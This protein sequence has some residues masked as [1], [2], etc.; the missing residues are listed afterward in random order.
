MKMCKYFGKKQSL[1]HIFVS[2][3]NHHKYCM[4]VN[5]ALGLLSLSFMGRNLFGLKPPKQ[6][7]PECKAGLVVDSTHRLLLPSR[8]F[9]VGGNNISAQGKEVRVQLSREI[10]VGLSTGLHT[11]FC[12]VQQLFSLCCAVPS[13]QSSQ[14]HPVKVKLAANQEAHKASFLPSRLCSRTLRALSQ[15]QRPVIMQFKK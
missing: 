8:D 4:M 7:S 9:G 13:L 1:K 2:D 10:N 12:P 3:T 5:E 14:L 15:D 11:G 6:T